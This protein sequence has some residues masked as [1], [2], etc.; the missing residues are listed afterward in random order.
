MSEGKSKTSTVGPK[1]G[2]CPV[3]GERSYSAHGVH[4]QC[5]V[6]QADAPRKQRLAAEKRAKDKEQA[7]R[8]EK[9][10]AKNQK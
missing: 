5:A 7:A 4:P 3:C 10:R 1:G 6:V 2:I 8:R 9:E